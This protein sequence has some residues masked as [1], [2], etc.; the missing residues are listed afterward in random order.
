MAHFSCHRL[1][2]TLS[3]VLRMDEY[4]ELCGGTREFNQFIDPP[5]F[6]FFFFENIRNFINF[7]IKNN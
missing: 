4:V 3:F 6:F 2:N 1:V 5:F 7:I